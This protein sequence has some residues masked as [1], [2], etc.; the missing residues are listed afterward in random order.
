MYDYALTQY[1][2]Q[3]QILESVLQD[4]ADEDM[5]KQ[6]IVNGNHPAWL[7][8]HLA[9]ASE[10]IFKMTGHA[11]LLPESVRTLFNRGTQPVGDRSLYPSKAELIDYL[12]QVH[13]AVAAVLP[14]VPRELLV[15]PNP[16]PVVQLQ[17]LPTV[18]NL[19]MHLLTTHEAF[20]LGQLS[21]W[22]R[23]M[24]YPPMF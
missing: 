15:R 23:A 5:T 10:N 11:P 20:H 12:R 7:V 9:V 21:A 19:I 16:L 18:G 3:L 8:G 13:S 2:W 14:Q 1:A 4:V 24:G 17:S 6:P 22:R